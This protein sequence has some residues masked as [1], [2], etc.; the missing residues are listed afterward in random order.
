MYPEHHR[1]SAATLSRSIL[2]P[3]TPVQAGIRLQRGMRL[4]P[5]RSDAQVPP[6]QEPRLPGRL[7]PLLTRLPPRRLHAG[8]RGPPLRPQAVPQLPDRQAPHQLRL[9]HPDRAHRRLHPRHAVV[10]RRLRLP[11]GLVEEQ[12]GRILGIIRQGGRR[13]RPLGGQAWPPLRIHQGAGERPAAA[14]REYHVRRLHGKEAF[15]SRVLGLD[16]GDLRVLESEF[17]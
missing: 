15:L 14:V 4:L 8:H 9:A 5:A 17:R 11:L 7:Q 2:L 16:A 10:R 6:L 1:L 13:R 3:R 12:G